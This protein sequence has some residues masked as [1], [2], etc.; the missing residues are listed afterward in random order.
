MKS[1]IQILDKILAAALISAMSCI[2]LAV[3][4]QVI[5]R[6]LLGD[7]S[8]VTEELARFLLIWIGMLGAVYA[9]R[10][11][12]H[13]GLNLLLDKMHP[14]RQR[15]TRA[16]I[17]I[18]VIIFSALVLLYGGSELVDLTMELNQISAALGINMGYV[19]AVLPISGG[20][21]ILYALFNLTELFSTQA[22]ENN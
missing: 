21:L 18:V 2:L 15:L 5:S 7:P 20:M 16:G 14:V 13:L 3:S 19:Y 1:I 11:N 6:Y 4:W 10:Q 12:A 17:Q 22:Q 9:Y 8:S